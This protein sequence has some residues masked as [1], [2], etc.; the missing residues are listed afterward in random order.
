MVLRGQQSAQLQDFLLF[1]EAYHF[2]ILRN[3]EETSQLAKTPGKKYTTEDLLRMRKELKNEL[4]GKQFV[5]SI[6]KE[7]ARKR[8]VS[9]ATLT[10]DQRDEMGKPAKRITF[11]RPSKK[12]PGSLRLGKV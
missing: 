5:G 7:I 4:E 9:I 1:L 11:V 2:L 10:K 6:L 8:G 3:A 12:I